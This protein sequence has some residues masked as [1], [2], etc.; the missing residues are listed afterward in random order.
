MSLMEASRMGGK[1]NDSGTVACLGRAISAELRRTYPNHTAKRVMRDL[2]CGIKLAESV[3]GGHLSAPTVARIIAAYGP[4]WV[5]ERVLEAAG[6]SLE[7]YI[8]T[9]AAEAEASARHHL[10][11]AKEL[12]ELE[13]QLR[14]SRRPK[15]ASRM[16]SNP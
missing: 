10:E 15:P 14:A 12:V 11:K 5:A 13:S 16:G 8:R 4:G 7:T 9:Q 6:S 2:D 1:Y 3:L